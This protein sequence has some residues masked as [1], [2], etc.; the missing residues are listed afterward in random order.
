MFS[1]DMQSIPDCT[2]DE[3]ITHVQTSFLPNSQKQDNLSS[4]EWVYNRPHYL[5]NTTNKQWRNEVMRLLCVL[6][7][8]ATEVVVLRKLGINVVSNCASINNHSSFSDC[9]ATL[10][11]VSSTESMTDAVVFADT[12]A[13]PLAPHSQF[14]SRY[15]PSSLRGVQRRSNPIVVSELNTRKTDC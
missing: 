13:T 6:Y 2:A 11:N 14:S 7:L 15:K 3:Y 10:A 12:N 1:I 9:F 4:V 8:W 5:I